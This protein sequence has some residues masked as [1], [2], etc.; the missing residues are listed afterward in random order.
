MTRA[1]IWDIG[2]GKRWYESN[3]GS[4]QAKDRCNTWLI[5]YHPLTPEL[6]TELF[7]CKCMGVFRFSAALID[8]SDINWTTSN[9]CASKPTRT[10]GNCHVQQQVLSLSLRKYTQ[11]RKAHCPWQYWHRSWCCMPRDACDIRMWSKYPAG[12]VKSHFKRV[13]MRL[14]C[15]TNWG[16]GT[17]EVRW[18]ELQAKLLNYFLGS[19]KSNINQTQ[20]ET[21]GRD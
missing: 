11:V 3:Q 21:F 4:G 18:I 9:D 14:F 20:P 8:W 2:Y 16:N 12:R 17:V 15:W 10:L 1:D 19:N 5:K 7:T 6:A 13:V